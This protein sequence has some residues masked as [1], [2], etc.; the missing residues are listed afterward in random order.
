MSNEFKD[1]LWDTISDL[2]LNSGVMD[3]IEEIPNPSYNKT[4]VHGWK[5]GQKV[6]LEVWFDDELEEWKIEHRELDK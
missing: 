1:Y 3:K 5:N 4:Y 6:L 2:V